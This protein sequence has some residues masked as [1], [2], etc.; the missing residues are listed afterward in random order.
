MGSAPKEK[1]GTANSVIQLVKNLGM[2]MGISFSTLAFSASWGGGH[3]GRDGLP[4]RARWVYW[5]AAALSFVGAWIASLREKATC[6]D[7][8]RGFTGFL[9]AGPRPA[10]YDMKRSIS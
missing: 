4:R 9:D 7:L 5:G 2:V 6:V 3:R 10:L 1:L 8:N